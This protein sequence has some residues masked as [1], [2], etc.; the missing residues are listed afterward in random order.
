MLR[1][2]GGFREAMDPTD[3]VDLAFIGVPAADRFEAAAWALRAGA[4]VFL[5]WPPAKSMRE[6]SRIVHLAEEA[7]LEAGVSRPLR[8]G[9]AAPPDG[10]R[11]RVV[12]IEMTGAG[13]LPSVL[14][15]AID[16]SFMLV[17]SGSVRR[18]DAEAAYDDRRALTSAAIS[19]RFHSGAF[20]S[21]VIR[22]GGPPAGIRI[23]AAGMGHEIECEVHRGEEG[24]RAET[25]QVLDAVHNGRPVPVSALDALQTMRAV[26][27]IMG[28]LR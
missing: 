26:E 14:A 2:F 25:R 1:S 17:R 6:C 28:V 15:D 19:L 21:A 20:A 27:R 22:S 3:G 23:Y 16:L 11:A 8:F 7:G 9:P 12:S 13:A 4:H 5:E 24:L 10:W 18:A